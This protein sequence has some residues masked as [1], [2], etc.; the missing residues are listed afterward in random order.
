MLDLSTEQ[1]VDFIKKV[2]EENA[3][4][5]QYGISPI[6][7]HTH[8]GTDSPIAQGITGITIGSGAE[9]TQTCAFSSTNTTKVSW[10]SGT[11]YLADGTTYAISAGDTGTMS[12]LTY[13]YF[14]PATSTTTYQKTTTQANTIGKNFILIGV[15]INDTAGAK[16]SLT[17]G[18]I[19]VADNIQANT[20]SAISANLGSITAGS[21]DS[22]T[23]TGGTITGTTISTA[24]TGYRIVLGPSGYSDRI[25]F[26][27]GTTVYSTIYPYAYPTG[28]GILLETTTADTYIGISEGTNNYAEIVA[29]DTSISLDDNDGTIYTQG[30][31]DVG[32]NIVVSGSID[33]VG[34]LYGTLST[35]ASAIATILSTCC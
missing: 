29:G 27:N 9:W 25:N 4:N 12:A 20:L 3:Y 1:L 15:A 2:I 35:M 14:D 30:N 34:D 22:V 24:S 18:T 17:Q 5:N 28:N 21:I 19:I 32:G 13:I 31:L 7:Y 23:I 8:N 33:G 26:M 16:Y 10:G 11:L 6:P